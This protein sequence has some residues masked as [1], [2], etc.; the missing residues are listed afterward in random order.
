MDTREISLSVDG[1]GLSQAVAI[2]TS[3]AQSA[4]ISGNQAIVHCTVAAFVRRGANPTALSNG[5]DLYLPAGVTF[6]L[7][8]NRGEKL[9]LI[10]PSGS[11]TAYITPEA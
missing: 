11:G 4:A 6:R 1:G 8:I 7:S 3:S 2:S 5:T 9:A 10:T